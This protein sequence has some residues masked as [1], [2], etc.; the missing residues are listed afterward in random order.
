MTTRDEEL[1]ATETAEEQVTR[2]GNTWYLPGQLEKQLSL[3][4][5]RLK[6]VTD[7]QGRA[8][9]DSITRDGAEVGGFRTVCGL[10]LGGEGNTMGGKDRGRGTLRTTDDP[11]EKITC[12]K[13]KASRKPRTLKAPAK[14]KA[15]AR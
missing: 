3:P 6:P 10:A 1:L 12:P 2:M 7:A 9:I 8:N 4:M 5:H 14:A 11:H 15:R 13:C